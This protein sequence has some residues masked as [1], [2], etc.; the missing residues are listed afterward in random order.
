[1]SPVSLDVIV[2]G[3]GLGG[4]GA[5]IS[6]ALSGHKI[7]VFES[8][9]ELQEVGAGL[10]IT[11]NAT[12]LLDAWR[13]PESLWA[14]AAEPTTLTVHRYDGTV[15]SH[16]PEFNKD[17]RRRYRAPFIDLH[18][19]DLQQALYA[20]AL[21]LNVTFRL[22][23]KVKTVESHSATPSITLESG[24]KVSADLVIAAD[25]L[26]S[27]CRSA[28]VGRADPPQPTGDLAY[29]VVL[30]AEKHL[31][32]DPE[33]YRWVTEPAVHFWVGPGAHAVGYSLRAG[34][35]YN[36]VLLVPDDLPEGV[37]RMAGSVEEMR[38][39]FQKWDPI[40]ARFLS[41]V[42][43][44]DKWKLMHRPELPHWVNEQG[45]FVFLGDACHPMLPYLAQ[46]ANSALEDGAVLGGLL[47]HIQTKAQLPQALRLYEKLRK[48]RG[49]AIA[50]E[51]FKQRHDFH[52]PDGPEQQARDDL[53]LSQLG[54]ELKGPFPSRWQCPD[55]QPWLYGYDAH[56]E[57]KE[58]IKSEPFL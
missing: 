50:R 14:S 22:G 1:M 56:S 25:G 49:D 29:R 45:N 7:T 21:S 5:A 35:M 41:K 24:E 3:A 53:F 34:Q 37:S 19:V 23:S 52:L 43:V 11:P 32:N 39:L 20:R 10:Q 38:A 47:G 13:L 58:A 55:V 46:G 54:K 36:I 57:V 28:F 44:V 33:L 27:A 31:R 51:T 9:K 42:E 48:A 2:V 16:S 4:L 12:R 8:A 30:D 15:L 26:W 6:S 18:R 17:I 40:L